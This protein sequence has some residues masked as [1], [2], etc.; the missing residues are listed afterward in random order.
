M[1][2]AGLAATHAVGRVCRKGDGRVG[3]A[4][5]LGSPEHQGCHSELIPQQSSRM[6]LPL[7]SFYRYKDGGM[8][9]LGAGELAQLVKCL[10][11]GMRT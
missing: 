10:H 9:W 7:P 5:Q 2:W 8:A 11:A 4:G 1:Q 3:F 6:A